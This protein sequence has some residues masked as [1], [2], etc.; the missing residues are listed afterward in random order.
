MVIQMEKYVVTSEVSI[1]P[2][3]TWDSAHLIVH[4]KRVVRFIRSSP[5]IVNH[6]RCRRTALEIESTP[7]PPSTEVAAI[8]W[9]PGLESSVGRNHNERS[10]PGPPNSQDCIVDTTVHPCLQSAN[11]TEP[12]N[13]VKVRVSH[14]PTSGSPGTIS[15]ESRS[16]S[17]SPDDMAGRRKTCVRV[18]RWPKRRKGQ[19]Y[20][21]VNSD[22][23]V[24]K[25]TV[26]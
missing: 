17:S 22:E 4:I 21:R 11:S 24:M 3:N 7:S 18:E 23:H 9:R 8:G 5:V 14:S 2:Y 13:S 26:L 15:R 12:S 6:Y 20:S 25:E 10:D 16:R 1:T 19:V